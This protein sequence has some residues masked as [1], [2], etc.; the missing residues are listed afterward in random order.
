MKEYIRNFQ[1][2]HSRF[3]RTKY[4]KLYNQD[5]P[6]SKLQALEHVKKFINSKTLYL[7]MNNIIYGWLKPKMDEIDQIR[8][9]IWCPSYGMDA[10]ERT[11]PLKFGPQQT[12]NI[13]H[14]LNASCNHICCDWGYQIGYTR[15]LEKS[16]ERYEVML[17]EQLASIISMNMSLVQKCDDFHIKLSM[18]NAS[19]SNIE[20][21][22]NCIIEGLIRHLGL[23][24]HSNGYIYIN[25]YGVKFDLRKFRI[26]VT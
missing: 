6:M 3:V 7:V 2:R 1:G 21:V 11:I 22:R 10:S 4:N 8:L 24:Y 13:K 16:G 20:N 25:Q 14:R 19:N 18:D 15:L 5:E 12:K 26:T 17:V 9:S 23:Q